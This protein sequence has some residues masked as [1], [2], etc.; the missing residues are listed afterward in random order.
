MLHRAATMRR[1]PTEPERRMWM[2]LRDSRLAGYKFR[3]QKVIGSRIVD[4]FCPAKGLIVEIDGNTHDREQDL[5][6]DGEMEREW[7]F[8]TVRFTN[9][10][11]M[12][13]MEGVQ[14]VLLQ[15]LGT[16]DDRWGGRGGSTL[17]SSPLKG[18]GS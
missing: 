2:V 16:R 6:R 17:S 4:F 7:G 18:R 9:L 3:R 13:N 11:V 8:R 10:E 5:R 12:S 1:Q 14:A 15:A